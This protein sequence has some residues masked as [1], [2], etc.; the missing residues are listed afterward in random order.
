M[1]SKYILNSN[2]FCPNN[3]EVHNIGSTSKYLT[4]LILEP[5]NYTKWYRF[6]IYKQFTLERNIVH[7][8]DTTIKYLCCIKKYNINYSL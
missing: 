2:K 6:S 1:E 7:G 5:Q 8:I 3:A 4:N